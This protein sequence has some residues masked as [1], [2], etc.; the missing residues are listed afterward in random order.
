ML[1]NFSVTNFGPIKE[2][3]TLSLLADETDNALPGNTF[4]SKA[5]RQKLVRSL[6]MYGPNASGKT[7]LVKALNFLDEFVLNSHKKQVGDLIQVAPF[8]LS[9]ESILEGSEFEIELIAKGVRYVY[10][11]NC[12][13][14]KINEEWLF[15]YPNGSPQKWFHRVFNQSTQKYAYKYSGKFSDVKTAK[16]EWE[17]ETK[18][19]E[20]FLSLAVKK[21]SQQLLPVF[22]WFKDTLRVVGSASE[23]SD[24]YTTRL[25]LDS[26]LNKDV[27]NFMQHADLGIV[28]I[29][30]S[31]TPFHADQLPSDMPTELKRKI[32]EQLKD[33]RTTSTVFTHMSATG[34]AQMQLTAGE[35]SD[36][37]KA[38]FAF[39]GPWLDVQSHNRVLIVDELDT[40]LHPLVVH[41]LVK[42]FHQQA[43][44][45]NNEAQLIFSTH[46]ATLLSQ[47]IL[48]RDQIWFLE[49]NKEGA[50]QLYSLQDINNVRAEAS[51]EKAYLNGRYGGIP[52]MKELDFYG[53]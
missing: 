45:N 24:A 33:R 16:N 20:L 49:K 15:A 13:S 46:D 4:L 51:F 10:G 1:L 8:K 35:E 34:N 32:A 5:K 37:T 44:Q 23:L 40:S 29:D 7:T 22:E 27:L 48:R 19:N 39:A 2:R 43:K 14:S 17:L 12:T 42:L 3:Q 30:V 38:M 47:K 52:F 50:S 26:D 21:N 9:Q 18:S 28:G 36:G 11:L 41:Q 6:V 53:E 31:E 25:C